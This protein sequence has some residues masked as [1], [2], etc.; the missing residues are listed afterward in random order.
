[1]CSHLATHLFCLWNDIRTYGL[2]GQNN[3]SDDAVAVVHASVR[4]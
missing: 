1:M 2:D 3:L 4:P